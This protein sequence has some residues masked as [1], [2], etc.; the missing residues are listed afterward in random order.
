LKPPKTDRRIEDS[1]VHLLR[2]ITRLLVKGGVGTDEL[3]YAAKRAY[4][5][6]AMQAVTRPGSRAT[7]SRLSVATGMTRK[8]VSALLYES[9]TAGDAFARRSGQQRALRVLSGWLTDTRFQNRNGRPAELRY[10]GGTQSFT[11]LVKLYGGDVTPRSV[12]RELERIEVVHLTSTGVRLRS[13]RRRTDIE[14]HYKLTSLAKEFANF[15]LAVSQQGSGQE[16][17]SFF[18]FKDSTLASEG[19]AANFMRRFSRR[20]AVLLEDFQRWSDGRRSVRPSSHAEKDAMC[21]G[22]GIYLLRSDKQRVLRS[23][24]GS[25]TNRVDPRRKRRRRS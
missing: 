17:H 9:R 22:L 8:Q 16:A 25:A 23:A 2:P 12:L 15:A 3:I 7:I 1:L 11:D 19:D 6:E 21:V 18:A 5:F 10:R 20:A 14:I 4:L 24:S 13:S